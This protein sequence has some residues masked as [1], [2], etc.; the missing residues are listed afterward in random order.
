[1]SKPGICI[2]GE[3]LFDHFPDGKRVL[4]GAPFNVAWHL[5]A[6]GQTPHFLSRVGNDAEGEDIRNA[7]HEWGMDTR[8][9][10]TDRERATGRVEV[11]FLD[12]EPVYDIVH[13]CAYDAIESNTAPTICNFLYHGSLCLRDIGSRQTLARLK[14]QHPKTI[15]VDVNLRP[16]WWRK[17]Q[18]LDML[19]TAEW[20]KLNGDELK[21]LDVS[22]TSGHEQARHFLKQHQLQGLLLTRGPRGAEVFTA[23][24]EHLEVAPN[25]D[26]QVTDTV[27]AGD[28]FAS[29]MILG[30]L[31]HW[32]KLLTLQRAQD[33]ASA[34]VGRR[35]ATVSDRAFYQSFE[36]RWREGASPA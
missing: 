29:V 30:L 14:K 26:I 3:V 22:D 24:G 36:N 7:M 34:I 10:Q 21:L 4:G 9:L 5:Q 16:P 20:V 15:F 1:M 23:A 33:F 19:K 31:E 32:P 8:G 25:T 28:A 35:G 2:F 6:F 27:G 17:E 11:S 18:V 12:T 13:P